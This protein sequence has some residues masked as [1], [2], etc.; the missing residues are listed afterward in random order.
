MF[1][2]YDV[3]LTIIKLNEEDLEDLAVSR[4]LIGYIESSLTKLRSFMGT[5]VRKTLIHLKPNLKRVYEKVFLK[6][7]K[8]GVI[9]AA[10]KVFMCW[11]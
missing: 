6:E 5:E 11:R 4:D 8:N 9:R 1:L 10:A 2:V 7:T 3:V